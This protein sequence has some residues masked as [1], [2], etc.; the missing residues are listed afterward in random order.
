M[1]ASGVRRYM[2]MERAS[3]VDEG[4]L[5]SE[6]QGYTKDKDRQDKN[7]DNYK[8]KDRY[9]PKPHSF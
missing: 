3:V 5:K 1:T 2:H 8:F 4:K 7:V 6:V 9:S